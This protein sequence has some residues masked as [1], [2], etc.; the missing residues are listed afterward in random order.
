MAGKLIRFDSERR[1]AAPPVAN[2]HGLAEVVHLAEHRSALA[3][4]LFE[5]LIYPPVQESW[6]ELQATLRYRLGMPVV[7][8]GHAYAWPPVLC[9]QR[10]PETNKLEQVVVKIAGMIN[11]VKAGETQHLLTLLAQNSHSPEELPLSTEQKEVFWEI[12]EANTTRYNYAVRSRQRPD[13]SSP[14]VVHDPWGPLNASLEE[15]VNG[16]Q[17]VTYLEELARDHQGYHADL[18]GLI[19]TA[20]P[21]P[22]GSPLMALRQ[23]HIY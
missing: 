6:R 11:G 10:D 18:Q 23:A 12:V 19:E 20:V 5:S 3:V 15:V 16:N 8:R 1:S 21:I 2:T 7:S 4:D 9:Q 17:A 22:P 14:A 13:D